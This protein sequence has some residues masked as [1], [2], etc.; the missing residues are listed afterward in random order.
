MS[1]PDSCPKAEQDRDELDCL[2]RRALKTL[3]SGQEPPERV[4]KRIKL[5]LDKDRSPPQRFPLPWLSLSMQPI[6]TLLLVMLGAIGLQTLLNPVDVRN[7]SYDPLSVVATVDIGDRSASSN[8]T[9][10]SE[11]QDL[12]LL[13]TQHRLMARSDAELRDSPPEVPLI[14]RQSPEVTASSFLPPLPESKLLK[15]GPYEY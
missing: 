3:M 12:Y 11:E 2:A 6:L 8:P 9:V 4:W 10:I 1:S 13:K 15:G 7:S 5:A 14:E